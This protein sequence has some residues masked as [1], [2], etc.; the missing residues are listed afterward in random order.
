MRFRQVSCNFF[1][2]LSVTTDGALF[3]WGRGSRGELGDGSMQSTNMPRLV[4]A[5]KDMP[6]AGVSAGGFTSLA[7]TQTGELWSW[8]KGMALGH[9]GNNKSQELLPKLIPFSVSQLVDKWQHALVQTAPPYTGESSLRTS[10][11][12]QGQTHRLS[13]G[14]ALRVAT[15]IN[16]V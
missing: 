6:I 4:H 12:K 15:R 10:A 11:A 16:G 8:G 13:S 7:L 14:D 3:A 5:L 9:G 2:A 1:H